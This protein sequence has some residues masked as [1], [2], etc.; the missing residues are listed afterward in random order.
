MKVLVIGSGGREHALVWKVRESPGVEK[1]WCAPGNGGIAAEAE[2]VALDSGD[3]GG[4]LAFAEKTRPDLTVVGP[5]MPLVNGICD[6]FRARNFPIVGPSQI[7]AQLEGSKIFSKEFLLRH[8]IPTARMYGALE[9]PDEATAALKEVRYPLVMKADGLCAGKGVLLAANENEAR[10]FI[11]ATMRRKELGPAG[12]K[13]LLEETLEGDELSFILLTDGERYASLV[14]TRDHKRI[15]DGNRGPNT[16]GMGAFSTDELLPDSLRR[17]ITETIVEPTLHGLAADGIRYQGF[18]YIGL[19]ITTD[20]PKV[21]EFNCRLGDPETQAIFARLDCDLAEILL[22]VAAK[23]FDPTKFR[24]KQG[25]SVCVVMASE[26]Y[27]GKYTSGNP[28]TG[29]TNIAR[30]TGVKILHAGTRLIGDVVVTNGGRVLGVTCA[31]PTLDAAVAA[32][33][34]G[35]NSIKFEGMQFRR[36]IGTQTGLARSAGD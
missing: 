7:A 31:A 1:I 3:V 29:L 33:Y 12:R 36:D 10:E 11:D 30:N 34:A 22:D 20:G 16:G 25:A 18:L 2:C 28:I 17:T 35:I 24:W 13:M 21:L 8:K 4:L 27:P 6:A 14:P 9:D 19:M 32:A 15:F 26:G 23:R 5:E